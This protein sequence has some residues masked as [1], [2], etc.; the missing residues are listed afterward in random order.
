M[1]RIDH[2]TEEHSLQGEEGV[3]AV[4]KVRT[5]VYRCPDP[6]CFVAHDDEVEIGATTTRNGPQIY[7]GVVNLPGQLAAAAVLTPAQAMQISTDL[8][9]AAMEAM[10][11][12]RGIGH[13]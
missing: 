1:A 13:D 9:D 11:E 7:L 3:H 8:L 5:G 4:F 12:G 10:T 2:T 6:T